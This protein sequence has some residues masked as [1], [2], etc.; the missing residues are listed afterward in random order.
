MRILVLSGMHPLPTNVARG[1]FVADHVRLLRDAGHDVRVVNPLPRMLRYQETRRSTLAGA[2]KAP[3][4]HT[5]DGGEVLIPRYWGLSNQASAWLT[6]ASIRRRASTVRRWL[7][8]WTPEAVVVHA[9]WPVGDLALAL[10]QA[11]KVPCIG[12]VHGWDFDVGLQHR[13]L[14][15]RLRKMLAGLD[16][17]VL[18]SEEQRARLAGFDHADVT[19]IPCHVPVE[20]DWKQP[21]AS[22]RGRWRR[23]RLDVLF[24]ADP[25]RPEKEHYLA[26]ET[27]RELETRGWIVG[28]TT[29]RQQPRP[30]V[31]DRMMVASLTLITSS[32]EAGPL[33][34]K[35]SIACGTPVAS[36]D[37]GDLSRWLPDACIAEDR[38]PTALADAC[39]RVLEMD[40]NERNLA[41]PEWCL[42]PAV[43]DAWMNLFAGL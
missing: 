11:W 7:D 3:A 26:L 38:S 34:A 18:V 23:D 33:V 20:D 12:V 10:A 5:F 29:L 21:V 42:R 24:P 9:L 16:R 1:T 31:W 2:A 22:W 32:R 35:E 30:I 13:D 6:S 8:G 25:R 43:Q 39:E 17:L 37:V 27:G 19:V 15:S 41:L 36:V 14:G 4:R 28:M 40:W